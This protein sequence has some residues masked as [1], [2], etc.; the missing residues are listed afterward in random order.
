[1][2]V[3]GEVAVGDRVL[4]DSPAVFAI[5]SNASGDGPPR[6]A[7]SEFSTQDTKTAR[8]SLASALT[9]VGGK[10]DAAVPLL[11]NDLD[12]RDFIPVHQQL[13]G[14]PEFAGAIERAVKKMDE[15]SAQLAKLEQAAVAGAKVGAAANQS[16]SSE[17]AMSAPDG[18]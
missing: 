5:I 4:A 7:A 10:T 16:S 6:T 12:H 3:D 14:T 18:E 9:K 17:P 2:R 11:G 8:A 13:F 15:W 1:M